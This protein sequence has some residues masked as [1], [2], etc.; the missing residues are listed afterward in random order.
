MQAVVDASLKR[1]AFLLALLGLF[2]GLGVVLA[3]VGLYAV[4]SYLVT[5]RTAE[6]GVRM[7]LGA[8][9]SDVLMLVFRESALLTGAG[10]AIGI[11]AAFALTR[12]LTSFLFQVHAHDL[13][14]FAA[15]PVA[16]TVIAFAAAVI[17]ARRA[18]GIDPAR[19]LRA[20]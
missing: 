7:A 1:H 5:Q 18:S 4:I 20:E 9:R 12:L 2:A 15:A 17:P 19:A 10:L 16:L 3:A 11:S 13:T 8:R 6:I 14:T